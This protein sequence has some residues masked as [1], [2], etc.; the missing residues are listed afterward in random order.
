[1]EGEFML[2]GIGLERA[3]LDP[4]LIELIRDTGG[5]YVTLGGDVDLVAAFARIAESCTISTRSASRQQRST[6]ERTGSKSA[7]NGLA[8]R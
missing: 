3:G 1:M 6:D 7:P 2:Y 5:G 8:S 4:V